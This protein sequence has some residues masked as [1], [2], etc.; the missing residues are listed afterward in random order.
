MS[1]LTFFLEK[2]ETEQRLRLQA[3][4][5]SIEDFWQYRIGTSAVGIVLCL[6]E[7]C[8]ENVLPPRFR[9]DAAVASLYHLINVNI[10]CVNDLLSLEKDIAQGS[11]ESF[12]PIL[13]AKRHDAQ[14]AAD[15]VMDMVRCTVAQF[16]DIANEM[17]RHCVEQEDWV[18][19]KMLAQFVEGCRYYCTGN[20]NW[21]QAW[22]GLEAK[23][24]TISNIPCFDNV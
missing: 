18:A 11:V 12:I 4:I 22:P 9:H 13:Y 7:Y 23:K 15:E 5:T 3:Q 8:N 21:R 17:V 1:E 20:L 24:F 10:C 2:S 14:A 16:D 6:I 19:V